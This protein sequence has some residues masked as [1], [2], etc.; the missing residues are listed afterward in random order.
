MKKKQNSAAAVAAVAEE[1][2]FCCF[3][4]SCVCC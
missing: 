4:L 1:V 2:G 3:V